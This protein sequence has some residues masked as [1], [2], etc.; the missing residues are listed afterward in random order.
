MGLLYTVK[1]GLGY[2]SRGFPVRDQSQAADIHEE[3]AV[4]DTSCVHCQQPYLTRGRAC[5]AYRSLT[6]PR[7]C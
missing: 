3:E 5:H 7:S 6:W 2:S 4:V 1:G